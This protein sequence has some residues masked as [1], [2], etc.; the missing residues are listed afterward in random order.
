[1][2]TDVHT[3]THNH[4]RSHTGTHTE[5]GCCGTHRACSCPSKDNVGWTLGHPKN[6]LRDAEKGRN[7]YRPSAAAAG[8]RRLPC[9]RRIQR[10][11]LQNGR[12][13][14]VS[15]PSPQPSW[16]LN[17]RSCSFVARPEFPNFPGALGALYCLAWKP[18][19]SIKRVS[20]G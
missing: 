17:P 18:G 8:C 6:A 10:E 14:Q 9:D 7:M 19:I 2:D 20:L 3:H 13:Y 4:A 1:M 16:L 11:R 15:Q 5:T 12:M